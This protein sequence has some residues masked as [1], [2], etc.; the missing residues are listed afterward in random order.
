MYLSYLGYYHNPLKPRLA[1][2]LCSAL[3][4]GSGVLFATVAGN[5]YFLMMRLAMRCPVSI[6]GSAVAF[7]L[8]YLISLILITHSKPWLVYFICGIRIFLF[9]ATG[10]ALECSYGNSAWLVRFL[11]QFLDV[12]LIPV[13][14]LSSLM[15]LEGKMSKK[16]FLYCVAFL[17]ILGMFYYSV[18]SPYGANLIDSYETMGR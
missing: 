12:F 10:F 9:S 2:A 18:I 16:A 1:L 17:A 14:I 6:V 8:P 13:L 7:V 11:M 3:A 4:A 5:S 15:Q